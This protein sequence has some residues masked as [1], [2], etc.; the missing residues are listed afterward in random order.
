MC[1][2][3]IET[4]KYI[5]VNIWCMLD[6]ILSQKHTSFVYSWSTNEEC[7]ILEA[8][9]PDQLLAANADAVAYQIDTNSDRYNIQIQV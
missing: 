8:A 9:V 3:P 5:L 4:V 2:G 6:W 7:K 1:D